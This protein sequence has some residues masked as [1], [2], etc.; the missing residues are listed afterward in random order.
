[1]DEP[2]V[3][4][5]I[6]PSTRCVTIQEVMAIYRIGRCTAYDQ[7]GL[8]L[9]EGP[10]HGIPCIRIGTQLRFPLAWIEAHI[11]QATPDSGVAISCAPGV[12]L[13]GD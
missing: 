1:M 11:G 6:D 5:E 9:R 10:G 8:F 3:Q 7:A 12:H 13:A 2:E 4:F